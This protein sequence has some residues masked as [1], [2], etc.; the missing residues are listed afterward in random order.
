MP[1]ERKPEGAARDRDRKLPGHG[2]VHAPE[3]HLDRGRVNRV[4]GREIG[5]REG[6]GV[7]R[8]RRRDAEAQE[9]MPPAV[10]QRHAG[11]GRR[12]PER[13]AHFSR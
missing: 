2:R 13:D 6:E 5:G 8:A 3:R 11:P 7:H 4:A 9:T 10:L 1:V 12:N